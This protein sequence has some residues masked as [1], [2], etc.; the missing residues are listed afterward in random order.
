MQSN[1]KLIKL[2][3]NRSTHPLVFS[4]IIIPTFTP[5]SILIISPLYWLFP[6]LLINISTV[7]LPNDILTASPVPS[8][9]CLHHFVQFLR[10]DVSIFVLVQ[11]ARYDGRSKSGRRRYQLT[12]HR[13][14]VSVWTDQ[15][16]ELSRVTPFDISL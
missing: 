4:D 16:P 6:Q 10:C 9:R 7:W 5:N 8:K 15:F 13:Y 11:K 1:M 2:Q 12:H 14:R 3:D